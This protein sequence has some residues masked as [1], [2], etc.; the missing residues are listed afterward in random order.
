MTTQFF[1]D[2]GSVLDIIGIAAPISPSLDRLN[3]KLGIGRVGGLGKRNVCG[4][5]GNTG[6][7]ECGVTDG[8]EGEGATTDGAGDDVAVLGW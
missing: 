1:R 7:R 4:D 2:Q 8:W 5:T 3:L 6:G